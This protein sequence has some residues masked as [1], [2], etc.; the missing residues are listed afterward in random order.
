MAHFLRK[1][2][3]E[4][5]KLWS[6]KITETTSK[7]IRKNCEKKWELNL[8]FLFFFFFIFYTISILIEYS[9]RLILWESDYVNYSIFNIHVLEVTFPALFIISLIFA[10]ST[11][12]IFLILSTWL[13]LWFKGFRGDKNL[14]TTLATQ[15]HTTIPFFLLFI[16][17]TTI[18]SIIDLLIQEHVYALLINTGLLMIFFATIMYY[19]LVIV[20]TFAVVQKLGYS[21]AT[22]AVM[23]PIAIIGII[24]LGLYGYFNVLY[25]HEV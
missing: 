19:I 6:P 7:K 5:F 4:S 20:K 10:I 12:F 25:L 24:L 22:T 16:I 8:F 21:R 11:L 18:V 1:T 14:K 9:L 3:K 23:I 2:L 13:H 17:I 15:V